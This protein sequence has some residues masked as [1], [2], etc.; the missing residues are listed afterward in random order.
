VEQ[1]GRIQLAIKAIENHDIPSIRQAAQVFNVPNSTLQDQMQG[2]L[3]QGEL[4]N[5]NLR[6]S[7]TQE[8]SLIQ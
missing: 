7:Q 1:E 2:H 5:Q 3:F 8:E 6:L 4:R